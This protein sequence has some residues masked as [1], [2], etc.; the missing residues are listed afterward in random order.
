VTVV[1]RLVRMVSGH[2]SPCDGQYVVDYDPTW[3]DNPKPIPGA[4]GLGLCVAKLE[5]SRDLRKAKRFDDATAAMQFYRQVWPNRPVR[6]FDGR[7]NRP[8]TAFT[9]EIIPVTRL[10]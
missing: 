2:R 1:I 9:A 7:P 10:N 6:P 4:P 3:I 5:T 8:L